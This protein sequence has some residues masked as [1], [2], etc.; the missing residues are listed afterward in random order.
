MHAVTV[1]LIIYIVTV[2]VTT[3]PIVTFV[4]TV[5]FMIHMVPVTTASIDTFKSTVTPTTI[6]PTTF[7]T[8][9]M[10][11][12]MAM[13]VPTLGTA[14]WRTRATTRVTRHCTQET[15]ECR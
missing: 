7:A 12:M 3:V 14:H 4:R 8:I 13:M 1:T 10:S 11:P 2:P 5:T 9:L 6:A 15:L